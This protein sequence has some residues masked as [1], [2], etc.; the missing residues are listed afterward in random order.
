MEAYTLQMEMIKI[1]RVYK[2]T[3]NWPVKRRIFVT[4]GS[5]ID[6]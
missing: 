6:T 2:D 3:E 1:S 5:W 4:L